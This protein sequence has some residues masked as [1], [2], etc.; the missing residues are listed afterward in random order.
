MDFRGLDFRRIQEGG[1]RLVCQGQE[2]AG[3]PVDAQL[4][5]RGLCVPR[6]GDV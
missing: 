6:E 3:C 1:H 2:S 4:D 5:A